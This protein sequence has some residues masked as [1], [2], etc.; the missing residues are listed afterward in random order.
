MSSRASPVGGEPR[1]EVSRPDGTTF[2]VTLNGACSIGRNPTSD[3]QLADPEVSKDHAVVEPTR[4]GFRIRDLD[5]SNGTF[6]NQRRVQQRSLTSGDE[7][8]VGS[9]RIHFRGDEARETSPSRAG[10]TVI[11]GEQVLSN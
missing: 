10:V 8:L 2:E 3:L 5:S 4:Q 6:V 7:I 9:T 1:L 11:D